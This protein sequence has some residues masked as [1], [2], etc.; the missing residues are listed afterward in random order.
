MA[1]RPKKNM[2]TIEKKSEAVTAEK[3]VSN[4]PIVKEV[5]VERVEEKPVLKQKVTQIPLS[6]VVPVRSAVEGTLVYV[7]RKTGYKIEWENYGALEY[8][9][10]EDLVAMRNGAKAFF[11]NNWI[12]IEDSEDFDMDTIYKALQVDKY[13]KDVLIVDDIDDI[14]KLPVDEFERRISHL[15]KGVQEAIVTRAKRAIME[16][17][18]VMDSIRKRGIIEQTFNVE[19][20][21]KD[22]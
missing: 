22:F 21:P 1:G 2:N 8:M 15:S 16:N 9:S 3:V 19:L 11:I 18:P 4:E 6:Y 17:D 5:Y 10:Y 14:L 12:F 7:S 20:I 13:Y